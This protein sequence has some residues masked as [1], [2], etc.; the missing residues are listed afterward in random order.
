MLNIPIYRGDI[1]TGDLFHPITEREG[2]RQTDRQTDREILNIPIYRGDIITRDPSHL[3]GSVS[4]LAP[5]P[6]LVVSDDCHLFP[7]NNTINSYMSI[8]ISS[9]YLYYIK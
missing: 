6:S 4:N 1:I 8:L 2:E 7:C 9:N 5:L 3:S